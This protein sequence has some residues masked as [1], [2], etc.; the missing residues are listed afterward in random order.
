MGWLLALGNYT[1]ASSLKNAINDGLISVTQAASCLFFQLPFSSQFIR[2]I[3]WFDVIP[4][5]PVAAKLLSQLLHVK[6]E[7]FIR[8]G[9]CYLISHCDKVTPFHS[10]IELTLDVRASHL[11]GILAVANSMDF[12]MNKMHEAVPDWAF[13]ELWDRL[14]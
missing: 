11:C 5:R 13:H 12:F 8:I 1:N 9:I 4:D 2:D 7:K 14:E 10:S 6:A 3:F